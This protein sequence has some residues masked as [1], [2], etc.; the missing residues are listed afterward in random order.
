MA[1]LYFLSVN[2]QQAYL[3]FVAVLLT[4][5]SLNLFKAWIQQYICVQYTKMIEHR[6]GVSKPPDWV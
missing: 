6:Q 2:A 5:T 3:K 4:K 1:C